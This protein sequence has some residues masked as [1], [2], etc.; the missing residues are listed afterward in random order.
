MKFLKAS[1]AFIAACVL[2]WLMLGFVAWDWNPSN[3]EPTQR[4]GIGLLAGG[5]AMGVWK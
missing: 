4:L 5:A 2:A 1:L 3:W